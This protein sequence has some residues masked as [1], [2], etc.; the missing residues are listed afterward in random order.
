M[1]KVSRTPTARRD[2]AQIWSYI[3]QDNE[4]AATALSNEFDEALTLLERFP[5]AGRS[6]DAWQPGLRSY[7]VRDYLLF[8]RRVKGGIQLL[9][10]IHGSRDLRKHFP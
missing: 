5:G 7:P 1:A 10:V 3:A 2:I 9:R 8:Y 4:L 6:R